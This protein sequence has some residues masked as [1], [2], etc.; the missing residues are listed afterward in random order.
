M[1]WELKG[2]RHEGHKTVHG[3]G[4]VIRLEKSF[5]EIDRCA[6]YI[7][8]DGS[9]GGHITAEEAEDMATVLM[10]LAQE[11]RNKNE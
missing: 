2:G 7:S 10:Y 8:V 11:W 1:A 9:L 5:S 4:K 3:Y 6:A